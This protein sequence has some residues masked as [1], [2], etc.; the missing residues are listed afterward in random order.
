M[1]S[2]MSYEP[3]R[4][5]AEHELRMRFM[6]I[7]SEYDIFYKELIGKGKLNCRDTKIGFWGCSSSDAVFEFFRKINLQNFNNFLDLGSGDGIVVSIASLFTDSAG[8]EFDKELHDKA[9]NMRDKL[10]LNTTLIN[11]DFFDI[12]ISDYDIIFINPDKDFTRHGV[13]KKIL[14]ELNKTLIV[15]NNIFK[16]N[17][18]NRGRTFWHNQIPV[19]L[20]YK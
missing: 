15:Y 13:E 2:E 8:I 19:T 10:S 17:L 5:K 6:Q 14:K 7:K 4:D 1:D 9:L 12:N 16:P 18:L 3:S 11:Q 20:W